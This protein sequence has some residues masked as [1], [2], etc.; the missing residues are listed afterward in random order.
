MRMDKVEMVE[1]CSSRDGIEVQQCS[2][3]VVISV[4]VCWRL[5]LVEA[6]ILKNAKQKRV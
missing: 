4:F 1:G 5:L 6:T 3:S 2:L